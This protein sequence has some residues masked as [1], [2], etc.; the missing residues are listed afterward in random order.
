MPHSSGIR[1]Q[2][3]LVLETLIVVWCSQNAQAAVE[4]EEKQQS[5]Q[6]ERHLATISPQQSISRQLN[7]TSPKTAQD[8]EFLLNLGHLC[9]DDD[10]DDDDDD[11][12]T[13]NATT[14][15]T[16]KQPRSHKVT[17]LRTQSRGKS[18]FAGE[19][20]FASFLAHNA[21][22]GHVG[23]VSS[24][25]ITSENGGNRAPS[26]TGAPEREAL[27]NA[28]VGNPAPGLPK[29]LP[30]RNLMRRLI[31]VFFERFHVYFPI[32]HKFKF[33][34]SVEDGTVSMVLLRSVL[35]VGSTQ[36]DPEIYHLLG[37]SSRSDA[38]D[39]FFGLAKN[40]FDAGI[41]T[42]DRTDMIQSCFLLH[43]WWG[44]PTA[45]QDSLWWFM[46]AIRSAQCIGMHKTTRYSAISRDLQ[47]LWRRIWW[48]LYIATSKV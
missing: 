18:V 46:V 16:K 12:P 26:T 30:Q 14:A 6:A 24:G 47:T 31:D 34:S 45:F 17:Q 37:F 33:L 2:A 9:D 39:H 4:S 21:A 25:E 7:V 13:E 8:P 42:T 23:S 36:C 15:V 40:S 27:P 22:N 32:L 1:A 38:G 48:C 5:S 41:S 3:V 43:Y 35:F 10:D 29:D 19:S 44:Q 28:Q 20:W 11:A